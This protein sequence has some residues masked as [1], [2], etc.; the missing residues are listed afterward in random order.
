MLSCDEEDRE[1]SWSRRV[2]GSAGRGVGEAV[3]SVK[4]SSSRFEVRGVVTRTKAL[5]Q[6]LF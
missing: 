4:T 6:N 2:V 5:E 3:M 1:A